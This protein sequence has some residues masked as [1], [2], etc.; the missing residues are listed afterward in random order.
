[1]LID[2][3]RLTAATCGTHRSCPANYIGG[4]LDGQSAPAGW[5]GIRRDEVGRDLDAD[6]ARVI[7]HYV[8]F[9]SNSGNLLHY[10][11]SCLLKD[12]E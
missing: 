1:M 8:L 7:P 3:T 2:F 6:V 11:H 5:H 10:I 12:P 9:K 4:R